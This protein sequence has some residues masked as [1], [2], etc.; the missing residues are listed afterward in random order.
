MNWV[1]M[2][3]ASAIAAAIVLRLLWWVRDHSHQL[4]SQQQNSTEH[5]AEVSGIEHGAEQEI[6]K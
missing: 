6:R 3:A 2:V 4:A 1:Y 5:P